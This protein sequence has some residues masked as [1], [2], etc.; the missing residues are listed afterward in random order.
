M[1]AR[2]KRVKSISFEWELSKQVWIINGVKLGYGV[3]GL[4]IKSKAPNQ[5][6]VW[7]SFNP[8]KVN[9]ETIGL[10]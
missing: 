1:K 5:L 4:E 9:N 8:A 7:V 6:E 2:V 10:F 3:Y